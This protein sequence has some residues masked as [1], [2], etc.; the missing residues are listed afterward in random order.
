MRIR[1]ELLRIS[2][3]ALLLSLT[4]LP[5]VF[6][7]ELETWIDSPEAS[8]LTGDERREWATLQDDAA[9]EQFKARY[10][11]RRDPTPGTA[12]NEFRDLVQKR[13]QIADATFGFEGTPGSKTAR[14]GVFI[15][16]GAPAHT[17]D[18]RA[19]ASQLQ[20]GRATLE[21]QGQEVGTTW[22]YD[23]ERTPKLLDMINRPN[24]SIEFI[25]DPARRR[26]RLQSPGI[27]NRYRDLIAE[28][29]IV[30]P[31]LVGYVPGAVAAPSDDAARADSQAA[32]KP[33]M[34][35]TPQQIADAAPA[36]LPGYEALPGAPL[37]QGAAAALATSP[38]ARVSGGFGKVVLGAGDDATAVTWFFLPGIDESRTD[39]QFYGVITGDGGAEVARIAHPVRIGSG[40]STAGR[41]AVAISKVKLPAGTYLGKFAI[42]DG[43]GTVIAR[44]DTSLRVPK[45][46]EPAVSPLIIASGFPTAG[47][48]VTAD[49]ML[50]RTV[51]E[52]RADASF[53]RAESLW[54]MLEIT[55]PTDPAAVSI[56]HRLRTKGSD[57]GAALRY[58]AAL[59]EV[60]PGRYVTGFEVP[61]SNLSPGDYTLYVTVNDGPRQELRRADFKVVG[62]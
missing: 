2:L 3:F 36:T 21:L 19:S 35:M 50:G 23:R 49:V 10:W 41:G 32:A 34:S 13:I 47:P 25:V 60:K 54:Y 6:A 43:K 30:N 44:S 16:F 29:S 22:M 20:S 59:T 1:R 46:D 17:K 28:K 40:F 7:V 48:G 37:S 5:R 18:E 51:I 38:S 11:I 31:T 62:E 4:A 27:V 12:V 14:G 53:R 9:R 15:V 8:F 39:L 45:A 56:E 58:K 42:A 61:L 24:L 55:N 57:V 33:T 52:A 26:D